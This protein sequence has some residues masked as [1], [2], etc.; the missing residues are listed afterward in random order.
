M[1]KP[2][3]KLTLKSLRLRHFRVYFRVM[4]LSKLLTQQEGKTLEFKVSLA[5]PQ[6]VLRS[7][8]AFSNTAGGILLIGIGDGDRQ[9]TGVKDPH[10][11][12][13]R[14][15]NLIADS[16]APKI[17]PDIEILSWQNHYVIAVQI[18]PSSQRPH[19]LKSMGKTKGTYIRVGS[20]NRLAD[21]AMIR[22]LQR[23]VENESFDEQ[24]FPKL[25][26]DSLDN[27][28]INKIFQDKKKLKASDLETL[29]ILTKHQGKK[30]PT[31]AGTILFGTV[32]LKHFPDAWIYA[33]RFLGQDKSTIIDSKK[34]HSYP[35][36]AI[37][38]AIEFVKKHA[39]MAIEIKDIQHK[40]RWS[41][42]L[43]AIR[44]AVINAVCHA[45]Y[46]QKGSPI[47]LAFF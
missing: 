12:E 46:S 18:Y 13:E 15:S 24:P 34:I 9:V 36:E 37:T 22:E 19:Y 17:V 20:S 43:E 41:I 33:G 7:L 8:T 30:V 38:E 42:P 31:I 32:R 29:G 25:T 40:E 10:K 16:I 4:N 27:D 26:I 47:R 28:Y 5:S 11:V 23:Y 39:M 1:K 44:E 2:T 14:L 21:A 35:T 45:D 3:R 6:R